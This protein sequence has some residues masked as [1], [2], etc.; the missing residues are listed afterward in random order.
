[1]N[2]DDQSVHSYDQYVDND[3]MRVDPSVN[4]IQ[5]AGK[6]G[7]SKEQRYA[8]S[9]IGSDTDSD[10]EPAANFVQEIPSTA[11]KLEAS[12]NQWE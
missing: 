4:A 2:V 11:W 7:R 3:N 8:D 6:Q 12:L 9:G 10:T 1:M 5:I